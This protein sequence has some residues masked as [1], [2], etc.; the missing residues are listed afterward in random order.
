MC[1]PAPGINLFAVAIH[2]FGHALGLSHSSDPGAI[3]YPA[4]NFDPNYEPQLSFDD[5]KNIQK[6]Y[7]ELLRDT[8]VAWAQ[9]CCLLV[10]LQDIKQSLLASE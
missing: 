10:A 2:E 1:A 3:M 9:K 7:G 6:L 8:F 5:V 4:Y